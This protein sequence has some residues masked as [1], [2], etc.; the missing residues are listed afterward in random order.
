LR[1]REAAADRERKN[2]RPPEV[3]DLSL[4]FPRGLGREI[5]ASW[6]SKWTW[7][8]TRDNFPRGLFSQ[9]MGWDPGGIPGCQRSLRRGMGSIVITKF[10]ETL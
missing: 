10:T 4:G 8:K 7:N 1:E 6:A 2:S 5:P 3:G 9:G